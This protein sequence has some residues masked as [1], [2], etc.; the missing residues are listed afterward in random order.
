M[1]WTAAGSD[2]LAQALRTLDPQATA[3]TTSC[4]HTG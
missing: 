2:H 4:T 3:R 1:A